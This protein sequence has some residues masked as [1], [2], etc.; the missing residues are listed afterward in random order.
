MLYNVEDRYDQ[1]PD[2]DDMSSF[3]CI[4]DIARMFRNAFYDVHIPKIYNLWVI[5]RNFFAIFWFSLITG[6]HKHKLLSALH[7]IIFTLIYTNFSIVTDFGTMK[8]INFFI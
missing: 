7:F 8:I 1:G 3:P 6:F 4:R 2:S 5:F